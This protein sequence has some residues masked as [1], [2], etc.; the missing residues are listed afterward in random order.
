MSDMDST[1]VFGTGGWLGVIGEDFTDENLLRVA[2]AFVRYLSEKEKSESHVV[3]VGYDGRKDSRHCA[4]LFS[5]TLVSG[6]IKVLLSDSV[7]PTPVLTFATK[8]LH[9]VAGVMITAGDHPSKYNGVKFKASY[10]GP[11]MTEEIRKIGAHLLHETLSNRRN[12]KNYG[13]LPLMN[14]LPDYLKHLESMVDFS[15]FRS[16]AAEPG[17]RASILID[18]MGG[19][20]QTILEDILVRC[21]WRAQT[22]FGAPEPTFYDR[23]PEA[24]EKNLE[25]LKY[26]VSVTDA[27]LGLATDGDAS[28]CGIVFDKGE[29]VSANEA[30]LMLKWHLYE[31]KKW[32]N[33]TLGW[34]E[35]GGFRHSKHLAEP[36]GILTGLFFAEMLAMTGKSLREIGLLFRE[37][38]ARIY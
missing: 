8:H 19:A 1:V 16:F 3:A 7:V 6:G 37:K 31:N 14:F 24:T 35:N 36:D 33:G 25:P 38:T 29:W 22:L 15:A 32:G 30:M 26:N 2:D 12:M 34:D 9:C 11:L 10:G 5:G 28:R 17:N 4:E 20:G 27:A 21:G 23:L 18:S 13:N